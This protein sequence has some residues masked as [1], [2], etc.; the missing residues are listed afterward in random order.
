MLVQLRRDIVPIGVRALTNART[1][2]VLQATRLPID[3]MA[4]ARV[5]PI[6]AYELEAYAVR[7]GGMTAWK[8]A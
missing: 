6:N 8:S 1:T 3:E 7:L 4:G 2:I 5:Y